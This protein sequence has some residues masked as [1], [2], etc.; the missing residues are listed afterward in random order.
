LDWKKRLIVCFGMNN[1]CIKNIVTWGLKARI[2]EPAE[3]AVARE[4]PCK[5]HV[6][7]GYRGDRG[8]ATLEELWK[9][10]FSVRSAA[11]ARS[12]CNK[13]TARRGVFC[14]VR[15]EAI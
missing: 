12:H 5:R 2:V 10:V 11:T 6:G 7:A 15:A 4:R 9:E 13:A 3:T 8:N 1:G 14:A